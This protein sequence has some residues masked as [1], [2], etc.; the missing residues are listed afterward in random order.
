MWLFFEYFCFLDCINTRQF[1]TR[2]HYGWTHLNKTKFYRRTPA[3]GSSFDGIPPRISFSRFIYE[4]RLFQSIVT[5]PADT[6]FPRGD[7]FSTMT[8]PVRCFTIF[9][10]IFFFIIILL[11]FNNV[12]KHDNFTENNV[13]IIIWPRLPR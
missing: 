6:A 13:T 1:D 12:G 9:F 4:Y 8:F 11:Y 7:L 2:M 3:E 10:K 5:P